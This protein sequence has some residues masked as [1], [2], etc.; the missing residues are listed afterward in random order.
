M[1]AET[2][3]LHLKAAI[4][5]VFLLLSSFGSTYAQLGDAQ[6]FQQLDSLQKMEQKPVLVFIHTSWCKYCAAMKHTTFQNEELKAFLEKK[7][8]FIALD[9]ETKEEITVNGNIFR[10][11]STGTN[12]GKHELAQELGRINGE[13][14]YP[15]LCFLNPAYEIIYQVTGFLTAQQLIK[16]VKALERNKDSN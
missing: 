13:I 11:R 8:Y 16:I 2:K 15:T 6:T 7:F 12:V 1:K 9:A 3:A 10:Y 5:L 4:W 14:S